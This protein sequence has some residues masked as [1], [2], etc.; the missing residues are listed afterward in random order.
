VTRES[1]TSTREAVFWWQGRIREMRPAN[2]NR[3]LPDSAVALLTQ[4]PNGES[5][6]PADSGRVSQECI[7]QPPIRNE[8]RS[9]AA[10]SC[11]SS[12]AKNN[13]TFNMV[14]S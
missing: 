11:M 9:C 4:T 7:R 12:A 3:F 10:G 5:F 8:T 14:A 2:S 1:S 13:G 6:E